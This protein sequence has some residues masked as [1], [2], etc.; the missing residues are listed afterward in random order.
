M[1]AFYGVL[2]IISKKNPIKMLRWMIGEGLDIFYPNVDIFY[3]G[4]CPDNFFA[5]KNVG[6]FPLSSF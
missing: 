1:L 4:F 2:K 5:N 6:V 3:E